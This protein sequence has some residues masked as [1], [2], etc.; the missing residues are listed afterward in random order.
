MARLQVLFTQRHDSTMAIELDMC[1][2][3]LQWPYLTDMSLINAMVAIFEPNWC[4]GPPP[5]MDTLQLKLN[6]WL[7]VNVVIRESQASCVS[8]GVQAVEDLFA[9]PRLNQC[10]R[11]CN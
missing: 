8:S 4:M 3:L 1:H 9:F 10:G 11:L 2:S 5:F 7:Y 6:P